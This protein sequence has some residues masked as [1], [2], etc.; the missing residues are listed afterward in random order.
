MP[1]S[2]SKLGDGLEE[3]HT[4]TD[5]GMIIICYVVVIIG[6]RLY[7]LRRKTIDRVM[8][9]YFSRDNSEGNIRSLEITGLD[10]SIMPSLKPC[11]G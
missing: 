8:T 2:K 5:L 6:L 1:H 11:R 10:L 7:I 4:A 3:T 9:S